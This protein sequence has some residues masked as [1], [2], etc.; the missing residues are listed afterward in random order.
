[1]IAFLIEFGLLRPESGVARAMRRLERYLFQRAE[2]IVMLWR[3]TDAYV[4]SQGVPAGKIL[5]VPHGV[6]LERYEELEPYRGAPER[7]FRIMFLGGF[8]ASNSIDS[9]LDAAATLADRGR[10][11]VRF[12]LV[13]SGQERDRMIER[14]RSM[15]LPNVE[16]PPAVPKREVSKAMGQADAF[17]YGLRDLPLY[18]FGISLSRSALASTMSGDALQT[19]SLIAASRERFAA[20]LPLNQFVT[21]LT[22]AARGFKAFPENRRIRNRPAIRRR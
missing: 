1:M 5:W 20:P 17:I 10:D 21:S 11:D 7:P 12:L 4:L 16:F 22:L 14:A 9:I 19:T 18:R 6:E 3:H 2:R 13:G 15:R 8:V